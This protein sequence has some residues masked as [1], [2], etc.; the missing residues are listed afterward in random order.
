[1]KIV[2]QSVEFL[3]KLNNPLKKLEIIAR[4]CYKS[5]GNITPDSYV[6]LIKKLIKREH[7]SIFEHVIVALRVICDRGVSHEIVR[8][9]IGCSYAQESTRYCNYSA[10]KFGEEITVIRPPELGDEGFYL[11]SE[12]MQDAE[13][14]YFKM[15]KL[16]CSPQIA[17][18]V[19]PNSLKTEIIMTLNL[20]AWKHFF[21]LRCSKAA[22]PQMREIALRALNILHS[23]IDYVFDELFEQYKEDK[24]EEEKL[25]EF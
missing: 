5:E 16:G 10:E 12:A 19:L 7:N 1:M 13:S 15:L 3:W 4:N 20:T 11:W 2:K 14:Y 18:S 23:E 25:K 9:R 22:H 8:H 6:K 24:I 17:R 21:K